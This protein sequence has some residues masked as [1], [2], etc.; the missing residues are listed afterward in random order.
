MAWAITMALLTWG[1]IFLAGFIAKRV[2]N[3]SKDNNQDTPK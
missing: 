1:F 2:V 3:R